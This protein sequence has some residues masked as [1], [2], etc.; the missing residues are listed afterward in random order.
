MRNM[1]GRV[2]RP[3]L[4]KFLTTVLAPSKSLFAEGALL[5]DRSGRAVETGDNSDPAVTC[6]GTPRNAGFIIL[7][8]EV[9]SKFERWPN[10]IST[11]PG[12]A[13]AYLN[14]YVKNR[15]DICRVAE[16]V[17][18]LAR[19]IGVDADAL[20]DAIL[21]RRHRAMG[22]FCALGPVES[23]FVHSEGGLSVDT[24][25]RVMDKLSRPIEGLYASG[26]TG[27]GGLL[28]RG[29]GHHLAW[30]F[31]S[32]RRAGRNAARSI[33]HAAGRGKEPGRAA[34]SSASY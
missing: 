4:M 21:S 25:H 3:L 34:G 2:L 22:P 18:S 29:H 28:L 15:K 7:D 30:A 9:C 1:A 11:A 20:R 12:I 14:D 32:G 8:A 31:V 19:A 27:Q 17:E 13:Y 6:I 5:V 33:Q 16:S 10:Y 24:S 26:S 23:A